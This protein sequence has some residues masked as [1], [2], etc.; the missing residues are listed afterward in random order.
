MRTPVRRRLGFSS[1]ARSLS[2]RSA[3]F[4]IGIPERERIMQ[5]VSQLA[6]IGLRR[7]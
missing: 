5:M 7:T 6:L 4:A 1:A 2:L 3:G